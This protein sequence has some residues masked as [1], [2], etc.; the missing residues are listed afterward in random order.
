M[1]KVAIIGAGNVGSLAAMR[2]LEGE[3]ADV[4]LLDIAK[5]I[6]KGKIAGPF[7]TADDLIKELES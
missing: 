2:I 7:D 1:P 3:L 5:D 6:A 4:V